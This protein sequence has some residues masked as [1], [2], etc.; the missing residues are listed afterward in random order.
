MKKT[1]GKIISLILA[2]FT[3]ISVSACSSK[4]NT[5]E[6]LPTPITMKESI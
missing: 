4:P 3:S 5:T 6:P 2:V 1:V